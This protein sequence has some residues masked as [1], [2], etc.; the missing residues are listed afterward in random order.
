MSATQT[1]VPDTAGGRRVHTFLH[2]SAR[3]AHSQVAHDPQIYR[4][5]TRGETATQDGSVAVSRSAGCTPVVLAPRG[6]GD[7][8]LV[9][10]SVNSEV[11]VQLDL[12]R[13]SEANAKRLQ[14]S[15]F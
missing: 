15:V 14:A 3:L 2:P 13:V 5:E 11:R 6:P 4:G 10:F 7:R 12:L 9:E 1:V 8:R